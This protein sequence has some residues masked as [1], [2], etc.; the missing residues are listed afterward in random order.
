M[1]I[2]DIISSLPLVT[3]IIGEKW[4]HQD[5]SRAER[6][7]T[8]ML[9]W[10]QQ[11]EKDLELLESRVHRQMLISCYRDALRDENSLLST[12]YEIHGAA[13]L[14]AEA[15][16]VYLHVSL[17]DPSRRNFDVQVEILRHVINADCKTRKDDFP[18]NIDRREGGLEGIA[19][20]YGARATIDPHDAENLGFESRRPA[21]DVDFRPTPESTV[22]RQILSEARSQ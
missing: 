2:G 14:S 22:I 3:A 5:Q 10:Y 13:L 18:F 6:L 1:M 11:L 4:L 21:G 17:G 16:A 20:Y 8:P 19:G 9:A 12:L 15:T 7:V